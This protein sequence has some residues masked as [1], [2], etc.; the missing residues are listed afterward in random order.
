MIRLWLWWG[1][2]AMACAP[3]AYAEPKA[4]MIGVMN[5]PADLT[6]E[7][8]ALGGPGPDVALMTQVFTDGGLRPEQIEVLT[9]APDLLTVPG[10]EAQSPS[11]RNI[12]AALDRMAANAQPGD[13]ITIFVAGHGAQVPAPDNSPEP[14]GLD[15]VFLPS[16]FHLNA[17][18][19]PVN[20]VLDDEIGAR[21]DQMIAVGADVWLIADTCHSGSFRRG[22]PALMTARF[23]DLSGV[24]AQEPGEAALVDL[25]TSGIGKSGQFTGF[26]AAAAGALAYEAQV[27]GTDTRHGLMTW[28]L[29]QALRDGHNTTYSDLARAAAATLWTI[30]QARAD[31]LFEGALRARHTLAEPKPQT[32]LYRL[33]V[34]EE[35][36][37]AAGRLDGVAP[38]TVFSVFDA[39]GT[40]L[41]DLTASQVSLTRSTAPI[42]VVD[43]P[44]L[45]AKLRAE[46]LPH[47]RFRQRWLRDR[48]PVLAA[49][50]QSRPA[51][52]TVSI[53]LVGPGMD[54]A[55]SNEIARLLSDHLP[56]LKVRDEP[57]DLR[58]LAEDGL[59]VLQPAP[60][61]ALPFLTVPAGSEH[62]SMLRELLA[63]ALKARSLIGVWQ[64]LKDS[65]LSQNLTVELRLVPGVAATSGDCLD[66]SHSRSDLKPTNVVPHVFHCDTVRLMVT[67]QNPWPVDL[68]PLYIAPDNRVY[69]LPGYRD[70]EKG[71][72]RIAAG[73]TDTLRYIE[74]TQAVDGS[75]LA[76]GQMHLLLL[77]ERADQDSTP[78][79]FRYLQSATPPP[80]TRSVA[81]GSLADLLRD[82]GFGTSE[83]RF[84][85]ERLIRQSG[86][87]LLPLKTVAQQG[88]EQVA[89]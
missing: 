12:L 29:A 5:Y 46:G 45:D 31:P 84:V 60:R 28:A 64:A 10:I 1:M 7:Y 87:I 6:R 50:V 83:R 30:G 78:I 54:A 48:A 69:F 16:D 41:F 19:R 47:I 89:D 33:S 67:N 82:A 81:N 68:T 76:T 15:E 11:R 53:G 58:L 79:D 63:N 17:D 44:A 72:W 70:S 57:T 36:S 25:S 61:G 3:A 71:G 52:L 13:A 4:L 43:L 14:D 80:E 73:Q 38:G 34:D 59:F 77:A 20:M 88:V 9:D 51:D 39:E 62:R 42:P 18:G 49:R 85:G 74:A 66:V 26:F 35:I 75:A 56:R 86:A 24:S 8:G 21:I 40:V 55:I 23:L 22:D 65:A 32:G 27:P 37:V 2:L